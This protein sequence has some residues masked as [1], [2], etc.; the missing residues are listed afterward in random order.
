MSSDRPTGIFSSLALSL[1]RN[2][3]ADSFW[4]KLDGELQDIF[5]HKLFTVLAYDVSSRLL[6]RVYSTQLDINPV[7]GIK[8]V[9]D[10]RWTRHVLEEGKVFRGETREDIKA[11]FS[12]YEVL[13]SIGCESVLNIP[14]VK[15]GMVVGSLNLLSGAGHYNEARIEL[16]YVFAQLAVSPLEACRDALQL[17]STDTRGL[18]SV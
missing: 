6:C 13:W 3:P 9:T 14:V 12:D 16:A 7:G 8:R 1:H 18:E 10:S 11:V 2:E 5:G 4:K 17:D 15:R